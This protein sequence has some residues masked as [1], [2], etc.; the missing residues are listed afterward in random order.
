MKSQIQD[1]AREP[2]QVKTIADEE[3]RQGRGYLGFSSLGLI[4][5]IILSKPALVFIFAISIVGCPL[6]L[7]RKRLGTV[8]FLLPFRFAL[9]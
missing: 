8:L 5:G 2:A 7:K 1:S 9:G 4:L 3:C 6:L